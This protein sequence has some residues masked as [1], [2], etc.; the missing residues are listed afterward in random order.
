M[1]LLIVRHGDP[2]YSIDSLTPKGWHE[3]ELLKNRLTKLDVAAFYCSPLGTGRRTLQKRRS[4][5]SAERRRYS[6]GF[7]SSTAM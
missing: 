5:R 4:T 6:T 1:K 7:A 3:A 2:D